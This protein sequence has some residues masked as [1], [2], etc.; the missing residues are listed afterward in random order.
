MVEMDN[1]VGHSLQITRLMR[2]AASEKVPQTFLF[3]GLPGIG[4]RKVADHFAKALLCRSHDVTGP[5]AQCDMCLMFSKHRFPDYLVLAPD[6]SGKIKVGS[7]DEPGTVR[8]F[9][10]TLTEK[11]STGHYIAIIDGVDKMTDIGQ[12][13]LLKTIEEPGEGVTIIQVAGSKTKI[14]PTILSRSLEVEFQ[15]LSYDEVNSVLALHAEHHSQE[16]LAIIASGGSVAITNDLL[17]RELLPSIL[18]F[19]V[20]IKEA[21]LEGKTV[22]DSVSELDK[23]ASFY[24]VYDIVI[25]LFRY[26]LDI[27]LEERVQYNRFLEA[28]YIDSDSKIHLLLKRLIELKNDLRFNTNMKYAVK[29]GM[30]EIHTKLR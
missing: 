6:E 14:L 12:N 28:L 17:E 4:K 29:S 13:I 23:I 9:V 1:I 25:N 5:C 24:S 8:H 30:Y 2:L 21:F 16:D 15:P 7:R 3:S 20:S 11:P 10:D 26:N 27:V 18:S 22:P 19:A